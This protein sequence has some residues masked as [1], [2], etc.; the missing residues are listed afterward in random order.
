[1]SAGS[2]QFSSRLSR[3]T[4]VAFGEQ[5]DLEILG[6]AEVEPPFGWFD[7]YLKPHLNS[8]A[9]PERN[10]AWFESVAETV[11]FPI[12]ALDDE[13]AVRV[14]GDEVDVVSEGAWR[15]LNR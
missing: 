3:P 13:S 14:R 11:D 4:A 15:L 8:P 9:F 5:R 12:Y 1:M 6:D 2:M 7:W 10:L